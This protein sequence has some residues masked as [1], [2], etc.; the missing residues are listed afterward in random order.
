M[1]TQLEE[2]QLVARPAFKDH[3]DNFIGG[4]WIAPV[5]GQYFE[6]I[7]PIDGQSFTRV[8]GRE[9]KISTWLWMPRTR[10]LKHG[11]AARLQKEAM[12]Y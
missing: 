6:N 2:Q 3:Y 8:C 5:K 7:S 1:A 11:R 10:H 12:F 9:K 4:E